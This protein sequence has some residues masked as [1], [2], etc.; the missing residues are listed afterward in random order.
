MKLHTHSSVRSTYPKGLRHDLSAGLPSTLRFRHRRL[1]SWSIAVLNLFS[2]VVSA[3]TTSGSTASAPQSTTA[4]GSGGLEEIV[5]TA[6]KRDTRLQDTPISITA[7]SADDI[8]RNRV[9]TMVDVGQQVPGL[10]YVPDSGSETYL[11]MRG[12][13]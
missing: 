10:T 11:I 4:S 6:T 3:Q 1:L 5:V 9:L 12:A 13:S 2:I 8:A 7:L